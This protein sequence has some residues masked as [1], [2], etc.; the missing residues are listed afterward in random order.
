VIAKNITPGA[1]DL[2]ILKAILEGA[3]C[4]FV[5]NIKN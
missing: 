3:F 1:L 5:E 4:S 2:W